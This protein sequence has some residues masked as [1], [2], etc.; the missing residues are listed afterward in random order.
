MSAQLTDDMC[1]P[2]QRMAGYDAL[3]ER[4]LKLTD[5]ESM[6][7]GA[8]EQASEHLQMVHD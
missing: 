7:Y 8:Y 1:R 3:A 6:Q 5:T 2:V 4:L